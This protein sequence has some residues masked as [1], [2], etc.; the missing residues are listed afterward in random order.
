MALPVLKAWSA[1]I[2]AGRT[3]HNMYGGERLR[4]QKVVMNMVKIAT[5]LNANMR[6]SAAKRGYKTFKEWKPIIKKLYPR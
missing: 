1:E 3:G 6:T 2:Q 4:S 5:S